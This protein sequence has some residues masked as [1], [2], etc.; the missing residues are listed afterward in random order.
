M[1]K[2]MAYFLKRLFLGLI[3]LYSV[4]LKYF[5]VIERCRYQ[6][7]CSAYMRMAILKNGLLYGLFQGLKRIGRCHPWINPDTPLYDPVPTKKGQNNGI[8]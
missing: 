3:T 1:M 5:M 6:P 7:T 2:H 4:G 8:R